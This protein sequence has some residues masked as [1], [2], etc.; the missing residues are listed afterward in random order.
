MWERPSSGALPV[1]A[2][3]DQPERPAPDGRGQ[4]RRAR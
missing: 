1:I 3:G 2:A 4:Q